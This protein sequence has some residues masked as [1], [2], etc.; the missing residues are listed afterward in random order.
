M[1]IPLERLEVSGSPSEMGRQ[2]GEAWRDR[3]QAFVAMRFDAVRGYVADRGRQDWERIFDAGEKSFPLFEQWDPAGHA[4]QVGIAEGANVDPLRLFT[5]CNMTDMRDAVLLSAAEGPPLE[6]QVDEGCSSLLV[7]P[8]RTEA[9]KPLAGQ[10]WDLN[11]PDV[12]YVVAVHREPSEGLRT[13]SITCT[14]C[15]SLMGLNERGLAVGTTNIK[16]YGARPG[17]GYLSIL[18]R[19]LRSAHVDEAKEIVRSAPHAGAHTYWLAD[20]EQ[21][22]EYEASPLAQ[23]LR[24]AED[25]PV[26]RTNHCIAEVH[27]DKEGEMVSVSTQARFARLGKLLEA[28]QS[29]EG[30]RTLFANREDGVNSINRYAEDDQG[31]ATNAVLIVS[32]AEKKA[33][34][35]RGPADRGEWVELC[36]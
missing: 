10:T 36:F 6:R 13:W 22:V 31:T 26:Y 19:A 24:T 8:A 35:C 27:R 16:T 15:L 32:P 34:A 9:G 4:E 17:V 20:G 3:I 30:L 5:A 2:Q 28:P 33:W 7:P 11:P 14:G 12:E 25:G 1:T 21:Q 29:P 23:V 18:H